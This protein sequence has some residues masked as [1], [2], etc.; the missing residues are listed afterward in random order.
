M[1]R[2]FGPPEFA[3]L[4]CISGQPLLGLGGDPV[5]TGTG[6]NGIPGGLVMKGRGCDD[7]EPSRLSPDCY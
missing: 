5:L 4:G 6:G 3:V 7:G 1:Y 2:L